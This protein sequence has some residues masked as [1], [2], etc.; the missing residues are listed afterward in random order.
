[1][2]NYD[3]LFPQYFNF[4]KRFI[5]EP[6]RVS[7]VGIDIGSSTCKMVEVCP[8]GNSFE[9]LQ[10]GVESFE[11]GDPIPAIQRL[12]SQTSN[13][14]K[15]PATA[16]Q[17]KGTLI[18]YVDL[19]RMPLEDLRKSFQYEAD[20]YLPFHADQIYMDCIILDSRKKDNGRMTVMVAAAKRD[21]VDE[22]I[23]LLNKAGL[24]ADFVT[25]NSIATANVINTLGGPS[26]AQEAEGDQGAVAMVDIGEQVTTITILFEHL[27]RFTRDVFTGG[28][29]VTRHLSNKLGISVSEAERMKRDPA[30]RKEEMLEACDSVIMNLVSDL[31]LSFD[32]FVTEHN[33][34]ITRILLS[35]GAT[36]MEGLVDLFSNYL[37]IE[38]SS[39]DPFQNLQMTEDQRRELSK[40]SGQFGVALGL[41]LYS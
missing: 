4:V 41:A 26:G 20:K 23:A 40:I 17:G 28:N 34:P 22:R 2:M 38:V 21:I 31:R 29:D 36:L 9:L 8:H 19:P 24:S 11:G 30:Q 33:I 25:L 39:W 16:V 3:K 7:S 10:W 27:P 37:E 13:P 5:P 12:I 18:R 35:G 6:R 14:I 32:Y 15:P 1:M